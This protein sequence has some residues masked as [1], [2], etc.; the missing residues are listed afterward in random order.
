ME[1]E[2]LDIIETLLSTEGKDEFEHAVWVDEN[3]EENKAKKWFL[4]SNM[5]V[6]AKARRILKKYGRSG[7]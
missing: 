5:I 1:K 4:T 7:H 3:Y 2:L 6:K